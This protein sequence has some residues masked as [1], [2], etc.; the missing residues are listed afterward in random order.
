M[1][2]PERIFLSMDGR[3]WIRIGG[4]ELAPGGKVVLNGVQMELPGE[5]PS[6]AEYKGRRYRPWA[7]AVEGGYVAL[8]EFL[9]T[10]H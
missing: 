5:L 8:T 4:E 3:A 10:V 1:M 6:V 7:I 2:E 9:S